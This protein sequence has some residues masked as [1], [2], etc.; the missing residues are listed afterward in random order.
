MGACPGAFYSKGLTI[1]YMRRA[2]PQEDNGTLGHWQE[3]R[4]N[5]MRGFKPSPFM[6]IVCHVW[7]FWRFTAA[8]SENFRDESFRGLALQ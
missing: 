2:A 1:V 4:P 5:T 3:L 7:K 6:S 8:T